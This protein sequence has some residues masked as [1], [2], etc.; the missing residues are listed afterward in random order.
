MHIHESHVLNMYG[1]Y[2]TG[3]SYRNDVIGASVKY[4]QGRYVYRRGSSIMCSYD[5]LDIIDYCDLNEN[6]GEMKVS[7]VNTYNV[8][9]AASTRDII[10]NLVRTRSS[11]VWA[12]GIHIK[13]MGDDYGDVIAQFKDAEG[14]P[15]DIY[16]YYDVPVK[17]YRRW[18]AA[19]SKGHFFWQYIRNNFLYSKLTG[20]KKGVL[21]NAVNR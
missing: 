5:F 4:S 21:K 12:Y 6:S 7:P 17:L 19:P 9:T 15:G 14:G 2:K 13:N 3:E 8:I 20:D 11:N 10:K 16:I 18:V 1:Y